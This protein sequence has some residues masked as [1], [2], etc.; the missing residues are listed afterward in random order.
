LPRLQSSDEDDDDLISDGPCGK[1]KPSPTH[2]A[3]KRDVLEEDEGEVDFIDGVKAL[4]F[5]SGG[6][7]KPVGGDLAITEDVGANLESTVEETNKHDTK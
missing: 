5:D 7:D 2:E 1:Q 4:N 3:E 6:W